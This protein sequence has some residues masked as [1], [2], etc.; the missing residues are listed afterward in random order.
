MNKVNVYILHTDLVKENLNSL[1]DYVS[2]D[3]K[4][5]ALKYINEKDQLLS[6]GS[7]YLL[8]KYL[9]DNPIKES[10]YSKPYINGGPYFN[11]SHSGEY[12]CLVISPSYD[13]GVDIEKIDESR[14]NAIKYTLDKNEK[15][16]ENPGDLFRMW[17]NK[18]SLIKC[19]GLSLNEVKSV[20]ALPLSGIRHYEGQ[21]YYTVSEIYKN[22]S[23]SV[24]IKSKEEFDGDIVEIQEIEI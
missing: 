15:N 17:S 20:P 12:A 16:T 8:K 22:Y 2:K 24:T 18:E 6:L 13:V 9:G 21:C 4:D 3:R 10:K 7:S 23:L 5:R 1:L 11:I 19:L 14:V